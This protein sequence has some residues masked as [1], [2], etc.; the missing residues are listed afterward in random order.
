MAGLEPV[1]G[2]CRKKGYGSV[3]NIKSQNETDI[4]ASL[5][6]A[7]GDLPFNSTPAFGQSEYG[8]NTTYVIYIADWQPES[9][10]LQRHKKETRRSMEMNVFS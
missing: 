6:M 10:K 7:E 5:A 2:L 4:V 9:G 3:Q 1:R 8:T